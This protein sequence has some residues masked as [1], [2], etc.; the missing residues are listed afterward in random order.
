RNLPVRPPAKQIDGRLTLTRL[1]PASALTAGIGT[2]CVAI[3]PIPLKLTAGPAFL[4][5]AA[6]VS[7]LF[8][9]RS[10]LWFAIAGPLGIFVYAITQALNSG[11]MPGPSFQLS[12]TAPWTLCGL[13]SAGAIG[14]HWLW[15]ARS[16]Q[17][18]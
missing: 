12:Y 2:I 10:T 5:S 3:I 14:G 17:R 8:R 4:A 18:A 9:I 6:L 16:S 1:L 15:K 13:A 11:D 7:S